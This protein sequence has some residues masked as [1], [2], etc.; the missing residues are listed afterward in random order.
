MILKVFTTISP[1]DGF[2]FFVFCLATIGFYILKCCL[3]ID[4]CFALQGWEAG[5]QYSILHGE[6]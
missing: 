5:G 4:T 2:S 3:S 6:S 1:D